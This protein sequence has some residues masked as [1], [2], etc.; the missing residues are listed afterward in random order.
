MATR[1][2]PRRASTRAALRGV[3][4]TVTA[5]LGATFATGC[6]TE[7]IDSKA[8]STIAVTS[9]LPSLAGSSLDELA[10]VLDTEVTALSRAVFDDDKPAARAHLDRINEAW[11]LAEP[12]IVAQ[13]GELADQIN[14]DL[15]RVVALARS[16]VERNRPADASKAA[17]FLRLALVSL[18]GQ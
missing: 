3:A 9:A 4:A 17:S 12:L 14:Y 7:V 11:A 13:F 10:E 8:T 18:G 6:A 1:T 2:D 15:R 16:A 5:V